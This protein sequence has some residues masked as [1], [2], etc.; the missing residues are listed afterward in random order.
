[1]TAFMRW[2]TRPMALATGSPEPRY[3]NVG[4]TER[5]A[6]LLVGGALVLYGLLRRSLAGI[7][8]GILGGALLYRGGSGYCMVYQALGIKT[9]DMSGDA[10]FQQV[11][12]ET[13]PCKPRKKD[14]V[15]EASEDSFPASDPSAWTGSEVGSPRREGGV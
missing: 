1:M 3:V 6:T 2:L 15:I 10:P 4:D 11:R 8:L 13:S 12:A 5:I 14:L 7:A 9:A